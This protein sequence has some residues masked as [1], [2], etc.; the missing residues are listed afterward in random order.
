[1]RH[2]R[3]HTNVIQVANRAL[4]WTR[5]WLP[6]LDRRSFTNCS[7]HDEYINVGVFIEAAIRL[8]SADA[9]AA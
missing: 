5:I 1:M 6:P 3:A 4:S 7:L 8:D 9:D 2:N